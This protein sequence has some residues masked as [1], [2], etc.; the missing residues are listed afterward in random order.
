VRPRLE[1]LE[2]KALLSSLGLDVK[3]SDPDLGDYTRVDIRNMYYPGEKL[4]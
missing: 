1:I 2:G 3:G 4:R